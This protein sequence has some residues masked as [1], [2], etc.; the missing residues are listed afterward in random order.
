VC[1]ASVSGQGVEGYRAGLERLK[2]AL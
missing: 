2:A 1:I